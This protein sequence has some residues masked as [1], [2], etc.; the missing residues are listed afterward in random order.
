QPLKAKIHE[1][2]GKTGFGEPDFS[3]R[4][5]TPNGRLW[6]LVLTGKESK[7]GREEVLEIE[8]VLKKWKVVKK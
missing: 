3:K 7:E 8:K 6:D 2:Y 4:L 1:H 5:L